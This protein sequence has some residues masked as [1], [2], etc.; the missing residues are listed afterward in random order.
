MDELLALLSEIAG[1]PG[2]VRQAFVL[3]KLEGDDDYSMCWFATDSGDLAYQLRT[4]TLRM[5]GA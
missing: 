3:V 4:E 5:R 2:A 1:R